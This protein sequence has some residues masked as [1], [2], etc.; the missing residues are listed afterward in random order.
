MPQTQSGWRWCAKCQVLHFGEA[1]PGACP[2]GGNHSIEGS[3]NY[4]ISL[5]D[6]QAP[7]QP[8]WRWCSK[9]QGMHFVGSAPGACPGGGTHTA[10]GSGEYRIVQNNNL[11]PGQSEWRWCHK[12]QCLHFHG[13]QSDG[14]CPSGGGH[15]SDGS[16][17]YVLQEAPSS[18]AN[19]KRF[20]V[21][22]RHLYCAHTT[23]SGHDEV[24][25]IMGGTDGQGKQISHRGPDATQGADADNQTAW[26]MN[27]SGSQ[28]NR[29]LNA[30]L[31][32]GVL[33][34][35]QAA[36]LLFG[37]LESDGT[38]I[39]ATVQAA[40]GLA[41][42]VSVALATPDPEAALVINIAA[43]VASFIGGLIPKNQDDFLGA[44]SF[45]IRN[46]NGRIVLTEAAPGSYTSVVDPLDRNSGR[47]TYRF[48][49]DDG[50][51]NAHFEVVGVN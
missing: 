14:V 29:N 32:D 50:D 42:K 2:A 45:I 39:G 35:G 16:G 18:A 17:N 34:S 31:Y 12:C 15:S 11:A 1:G 10:V 25:Y 8:G 33:S 43:D 48:Q 21:I 51:Y 44:F 30:I 36:T 37:F 7:G 46:Q 26:D 28:Q 5:N 19:V 3:G 9:C 38:D 27:D 24:Y 4:V 22:L 47:I 49:H 6:G 13:N 23:E 40:A 20:Q 41:Q